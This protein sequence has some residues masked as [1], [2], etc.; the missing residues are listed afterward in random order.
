VRIEFS[1]AFLRNNE[2]DPEWLAGLPTLLEELA[3]RWQLRLEPR[4]HGGQVNYVAPAVRA[5]GHRCVLKVTRFVGEM[6]TEIAALR[7]WAG[8]GAVRLLDAD[9]ERGA[10][11]LER[12]DP[13]SMLVE[14]AKQDDDAATLVAVAVLRE[15]WQ[16]VP[17]EHELR[18]LESWCAGYERNR[19]VLTAGTNGF[20]KQLFL[21][22][23]AL[24][25][26]LLASTRAHSVLHGDMHHYN[27][28]RA[29]RADW[30]AIDPKGLA[31]DRCFDVCQF[32]RNPRRVDVSFNRRRLDI[33]SA[34]LALDR[35]RVKDWCLVHAV[36]DACW[37][38]EDGKPWQ[39]AVE[40]A[41]LTLTF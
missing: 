19:D 14:L 15:L 24:R 5:N 36:L 41:E 17:F 28:L 35:A 1:P 30:L 29:Q 34:E 7:I 26:E 12:L 13:G 32:F 40:Y 4:F 21:R 25:R 22:A 11:L 37:D 31:G 23:D 38:F 20:P 27:V 33:F 10:L 8:E 16:P 3:R 6:R 39:P 2:V 9:L 18:S